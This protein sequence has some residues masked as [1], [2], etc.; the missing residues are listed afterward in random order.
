MAAGESERKA[1]WRKAKAK[2]QHGNK[3]GISKMKSSK[4]NGV[5]SYENDVIMVIINESI[6]R[7]ANNDVMK[8]R[9]RN[10][11]MASMKSINIISKQQITK[12]KR[13]G[14]NG[15]AKIIAA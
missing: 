8:K 3:Y 5:I 2:Q 14:S 13:S 10:G 15:M 9:K 7:K 11:V 4:R 12:I 1:A 6:E